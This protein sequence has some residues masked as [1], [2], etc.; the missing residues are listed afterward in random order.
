VREGEG[1]TAGVLESPGAGFE[2]VCRQ[3]IEVASLEAL[4][5]VAAYSDERAW[6]GGQTWNRC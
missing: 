1:V 6:G 4:A 3:V 5:Q 2:K